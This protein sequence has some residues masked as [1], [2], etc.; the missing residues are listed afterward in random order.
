MVLEVEGGRLHE[1]KI[2]VQRGTLSKRLPDF[3]RVGCE[4]PWALAWRSMVSA[5]TGHKVTHNDDHLRL[6]MTITQV[7]MVYYMQCLN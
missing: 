1:V 2:T 6:Q 4:C 3:A 7:H 5:V